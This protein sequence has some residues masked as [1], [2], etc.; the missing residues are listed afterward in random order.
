MSK[1]TLPKIFAELLKSLDENPSMEERG[2]LERFIN[3]NSDQYHF[4]EEFA[5]L[6]EKIFVARLS[7]HEFILNPD[8]Y[9]YALQV[10][11]V[12][13]ILSRDPKLLV[14]DI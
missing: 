13:R 14:R 7:F 11:Q 12:L 4:P 9:S 8:L 1:K 6:L 2:L 10:L 5:A 3:S